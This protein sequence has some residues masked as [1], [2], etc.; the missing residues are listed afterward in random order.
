MKNVVLLVPVAFVLGG[1][2]GYVGPYEELRAIKESRETVV[3]E[4]R[5]ARANGFGAFAQMVKIPDVATRRSRPAA[6]R[7]EASE[8]MASAS[9][10]VARAES[11][12]NHRDASNP[13]RLRAH[14]SGSDLRV[15]IE[16]AADLWRARTEIVRSSA[17]SKL[18]LDA[19]GATA[20]DTAVATMNERLHDSVSALA[21]QL[22]ASEEMTPELGVRLM[23]DLSTTLAETYEMIGASVGEERRADVSKLQLIEFVDP[24]VAEPLIAVQEKLEGFGQGEPR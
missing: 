12:A 21:E 24:T 14:E 11:L 3:R 9:N 2:V 17:I 18:G 4:S 22:A 19:A 6:S 7:Q 23:G 8:E 13:K 20:L 5:P 1:L 16:E 15:R 10:S